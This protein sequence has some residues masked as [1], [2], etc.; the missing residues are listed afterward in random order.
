MSQFWT[1]NH[2]VSNALASVMFAGASQIALGI[3]DLWTYPNVRLARLK[4]M[5]AKQNQ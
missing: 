1:W 4:D 2:S 3:L 5:Q